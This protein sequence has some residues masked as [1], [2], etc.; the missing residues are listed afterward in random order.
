MFAI[1]F[2]VSLAISMH[3]IL[4]SERETDNS[5]KPA[6]L[7]EIKLFPRDP[8]ISAAAAAS[9]NSALSSFKLG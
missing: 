5:W 1:H 4:I 7:L 2:Y 8:K 3:L 9:A 6:L